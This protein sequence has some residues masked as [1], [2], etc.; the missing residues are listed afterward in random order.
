VEKTILG[1]G[2]DKLELR[3]VA[4][5]CKMDRL[6]QFVSQT[7]ISP[8]SRNVLCGRFSHVFFGLAQKFPPLKEIFFVE[9]SAICIVY[10]GKVKLDFALPSESDLIQPLN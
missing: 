8:S 6:K 7:K 1:P 10:A 4:D 5:L 3:E 2:R 9:G